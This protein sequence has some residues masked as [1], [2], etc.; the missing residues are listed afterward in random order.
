MII[1]HTTLNLAYLNQW[2]PAKQCQKRFKWALKP[3]W[4]GEKR[5][6]VTIDA[7]RSREKGWQC[8]SVGKRTV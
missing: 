3:V 4:L 8:Q 5:Q 1:T 2:Q 7:S 6:K